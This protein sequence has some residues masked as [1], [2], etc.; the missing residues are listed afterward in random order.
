MQNNGAMKIVN[1]MHVQ[2]AETSFLPSANAGYEANTCML[3]HFNSPNRSVDDLT[4]IVIDRLYNQDTVLSKLREDWW[5][6]TLNTITPNGLN[7][8]G[9]NSHI[10]H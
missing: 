9:D 2:M 8:R 1:F 6:N 4:V 7:L 10:Q 3:S 5:I